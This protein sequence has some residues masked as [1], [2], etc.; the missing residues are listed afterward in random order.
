MK[1]SVERNEL[2]IQNPKT[3]NKK[4]RRNTCKYKNIYFYEYNIQNISK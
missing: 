3:M 2:I 1:V 4:E